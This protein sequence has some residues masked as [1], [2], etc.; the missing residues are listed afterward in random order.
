MRRYDTCDEGA[1]DQHTGIQSDIECQTP[2]A[3]LLDQTPPPL[4]S[5]R[6]RRRLSSSGGHQ[7]KDMC[8]CRLSGARQRS[9]GPAPA[10]PAPA[11]RVRDFPAGN[12]RQFSPVSSLFTQ[13][14]F[15]AAD[16]QGMS[17]RLK[18]WRSDRARGRLSRGSKCE[19]KMFTPPCCRQRNHGPRGSDAAARC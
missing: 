13:G 11:E 9:F 18:V 8:P 12:L 17:T 2:R 10:E 3:G 1:V 5:S 6:C 14:I 16:G 7:G 19:S 4:I 15:N